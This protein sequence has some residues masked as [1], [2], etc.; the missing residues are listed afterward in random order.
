MKKYDYFKR[1]L[2]FNIL[3]GYVVFEIETLYKNRANLILYMD[4]NGIL[5]LMFYRD[6]YNKSNKIVDFKPIHGKIDA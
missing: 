5:R 1:V 6:G 3:D 4:D 2:S